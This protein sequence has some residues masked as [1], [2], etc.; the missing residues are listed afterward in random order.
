M[1]VDAFPRPEEVGAVCVSPSPF[2]FCLC[3][4]SMRVSL[5]VLFVGW[6]VGVWS[7]FTLAAAEDIYYDA[8]FAC[9]FFFF[10]SPMSKLGSFPIG[11][12]APPLVILCCFC[13]IGDDYITLLYSPAGGA[14]PFSSL[15]VRRDS[16]EG[17]IRAC[18]LQLFFP[19]VLFFRAGRADENTR[20]VFSVC[21]SLVRYEV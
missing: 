1:L 18:P 3:V 7:C 20:R 17:L 6:F 10:I 16:S 9:L 13:A 12:K 11:K 4:S 15:L 2:F 14:F 8:F 19:S 21:S 5:C